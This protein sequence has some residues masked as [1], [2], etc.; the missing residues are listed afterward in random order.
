MHPVFLEHFLSTHTHT[1]TKRAPYI[2]LREAETYERNQSLWRAHGNGTSYIL[3]TLPYVHSVYYTQWTP[4]KQTKRTKKSKHKENSG[5]VHIR[6]II[7]TVK[8]AYPCVVKI[9]RFNITSYWIET[10]HKLA[11]FGDVK[12]FMVNLYPY[13][14]VQYVLREARVYLL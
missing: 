5:T 7:K 11:C 3:H 4:S 12:R 13:L 8:K 6:W 10:H 1:Q 14:C 2:D 9:K